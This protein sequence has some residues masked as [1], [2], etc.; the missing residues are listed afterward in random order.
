[1]K[2]IL[3]FH[4]QPLFI[5]PTMDTAAVMDRFLSGDKF[6]ELRNFYVSSIVFDVQIVF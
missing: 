1:M 5:A 3:V 6:Q 4:D 2:D